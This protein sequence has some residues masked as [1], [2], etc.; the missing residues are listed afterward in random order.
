M[1]SVLITNRR[2]VMAFMVTLGLFMLALIAPGKALAQGHICGPCAGSSEYRI[3]IGNW[4]IQL[5]YCGVTVGK[6]NHFTGTTSD[7]THSNL[8]TGNYDYQFFPSNPTSQ[9]DVSYVTV[10]TNLGTIVWVAC[11]DSTSECFYLS[12]GSQ[13]ACVKISFWQSLNPTDY[14]YR[15]K[16]EAINCPCP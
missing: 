7:A 15:I 4:P 12:N 16:I 3:E 13:F 2:I 14:C 5:G 6:V 9:W 10:M 11:V 8:L 1:R